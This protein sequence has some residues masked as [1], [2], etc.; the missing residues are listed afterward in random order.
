MRPSLRS[1]HGTATAERPSTR[2]TQSGGMVVVVLGIAVM[3][4]S[5]RPPTLREVA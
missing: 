3:L 2:R 4:L 1:L 5:R